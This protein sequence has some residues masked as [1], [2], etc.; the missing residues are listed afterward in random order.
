[1]EPHI[2]ESRVAELLTLAVTQSSLAPEFEY[3]R[4]ALVKA[5]LFGVLAR[6]PHPDYMFMNEAFVV[7]HATAMERILKQY[8][9]GIHTNLGT[10]GLIP[11]NALRFI[12]IADMAAPLPDGIH[13]GLVHS[14]QGAAKA[15]GGMSGAGLVYNALVLLKGRVEAAILEYNTRTANRLADLACHV[16]VRA[17]APLLLCD[18]THL[19]FV[20]TRYVFRPLKNPA[21]SRRPRA[22]LQMSVAIWMSLVALACSTLKLTWS[23]RLS[24]SRLLRLDHRPLPISAHRRYPFEFGDDCARMAATWRCHAGDM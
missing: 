21:N 7:E 1:M 17:Q 11:G 24:N 4:E 8:K 10:K 9:D 22:A 2:N 12:N 3:H 20:A 13:N 5:A 18:C 23:M 19:P 16:P 14:I 15:I 6:V